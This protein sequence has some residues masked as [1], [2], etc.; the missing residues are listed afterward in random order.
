[1]QR[2]TRG[3]AVGGGFDFGIN[4][5][6]TIWHGE[7]ILHIARAA[8]GHR[9]QRDVAAGD[10]VDLLATAQAYGDGDFL[11]LIGLRGAG[12]NACAVL[13]HPVGIADRGVNVVQLL[14]SYI[15]RRRGAAGQLRR[16][17]RAVAAD[18]PV[19]AGIRSDGVAV[20]GGHG[21][22]DTGAFDSFK[23]ES[24]SGLCHIYTDAV[25]QDR[26]IFDVGVALD[27]ERNR[28]SF[29]LCAGAGAG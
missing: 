24:A 1:M 11:P 26:H 6:I 23:A 25:H 12:G 21:Y 16:E 9:P 27:T 19:G 8:A 15:E 14:G 22:I 29:G 4:R 17:N 7:S 18:G 13:V 5:N 10:L 20:L 3:D 28:Y 2:G